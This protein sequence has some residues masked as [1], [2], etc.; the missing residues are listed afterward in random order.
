MPVAFLC[1]IC[2]FLKEPHRSCFQNTEVHSFSPFVALSECQ[3]LGLPPCC[4]LEVIS[5]LGSEEW[6]MIEKPWP[7]T[8]NTV[9]L[10]GYAFILS[11]HS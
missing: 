6:P 4:C 11:N 7:N 5:V 1:W 9:K 10:E 8:V 3:S 2:F